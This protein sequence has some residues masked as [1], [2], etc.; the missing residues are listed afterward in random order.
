MASIATCSL[1]ESSS[2]FVTSAQ[3][4][5]QG[6]KISVEAG[7]GVKSGIPDSAYQVAVVE[8]KWWF[9]I[10]LSWPIIGA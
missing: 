3:P 10:S 5:L 1:P 9:M 8:G 7:A 4:R 6:Y 2:D